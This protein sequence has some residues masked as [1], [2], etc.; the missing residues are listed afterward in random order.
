LI[1][2]WWTSSRSMVLPN[3]GFRF[4]GMTF[5]PTFQTFGVH[6]GNEIPECFI[7]HALVGITNVEDV[8]NDEDAILC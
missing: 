8:R 7:V 1:H 2:I 3:V 6:R 4:D 5:A